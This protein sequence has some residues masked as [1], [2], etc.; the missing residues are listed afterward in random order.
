V[1]K[2]IAIGHGIQNYSCTSTTGNFSATGA[3]AVLYDATSLY[4]GT[5]KTGLNQQKWD[6]LPSNLLWNSALPLNK[7]P[8]ST[9]GADPTK[10][11]PDPADLTLQGLPKIKFLGHHFFDAKGVPVFDLS[12]AG[13]KAVVKKV[14]AVAPPSNADVGIVGSGAVQW[15]QLDDNLS[16]QCV[17]V[18]TVYR[19]ITAGGNAQACSVAGVGVQSVPYTTFYWFYG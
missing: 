2:K 18:K 7:L 12:A 1:L 16:G 8:G 11:F 5:R 4:P 13:F 10:P 9:Y 19:V 3:L 17:G 6:S 15:L 14:D